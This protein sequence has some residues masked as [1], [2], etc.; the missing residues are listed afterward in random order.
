MD[1]SVPPSCRVRRIIAEPSRWPAS[2]N[3]ARTRDRLQMAGRNHRLSIAPKRLRHQTGYITAPPD[4][5][6]PG[7]F[8]IFPGGVAFLDMRAV[9]QHDG[10]KLCCQTGG[11][12]GPGISLLDQQRK[13]PGMV[14][15]SVGYQHVINRARCKRAGCCCLC[16]PRPVAARSR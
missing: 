16:P 4:P 5:A 9:S 14:N 3:S 7:G 12:N 11:D 2:K 6:R 1:F 15:M 10:Q 13:P 8:L